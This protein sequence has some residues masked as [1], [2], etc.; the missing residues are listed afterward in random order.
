MSFESSARARTRSALPTVFAPFRTPSSPDRWL[1][2][3]AK[4]KGCVKVPDIRVPQLG[5]V[6]CSSID[7]PVHFGVA[8]RKHSR[9]DVASTG[10]V[11][12]SANKSRE[13]VNIDQYVGD[14]A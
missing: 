13:V 12:T 7:D 3:K 9:D 8:L 11:L 2:Y 14:R 1:S 10:L 6:C 4:P 5:G